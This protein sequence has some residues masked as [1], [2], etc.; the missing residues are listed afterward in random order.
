MNRMR[1][2]FQ[3]IIMHRV[4]GAVVAAAWMLSA[5]AGARAQL[6]IFD[7]LDWVMDRGANT[8]STV[9]PN[10]PGPGTG[11]AGIALRQGVNNFNQRFPLLG[12]PDPTSLLNNDPWKA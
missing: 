2:R 9:P 7:G 6:P 1:I 5:A 8:F 11:S 10:P 4:L 3:D 12:N